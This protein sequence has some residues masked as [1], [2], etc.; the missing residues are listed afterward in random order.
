MLKTL[1][2][3]N[4]LSRKIELNEQI[5]EILSQRLYI[6]KSTIKNKI[7]MINVRVCY[8]DNNDISHK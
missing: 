7:K 6:I 4:V 2:D 8:K 5:E 3:Y 1:Y